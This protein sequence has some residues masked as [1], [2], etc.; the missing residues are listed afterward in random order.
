M[1]SPVPGAGF[2][3]NCANR[4][5]RSRLSL[6]GK[7]VGMRL[8]ALL[9][10]GAVVAGTVGLP[11]ARAEYP[12]VCFA[13]VEGVSKRALVSASPAAE[14]AVATLVAR[15]GGR[16]GARIEPVGVRHV[17]LPSAAVRDAVVAALSATPG[18]RWAEP[19]LLV[20]AHR[21][22]NDPMARGQWAIDKIGLRRA[23]DVTTGAASVTVAV[24]DTGVAADHPDLKGKVLPG[25]DVVNDDEDASDD[26]GHGTH[27][28]GTVAAASNNRR[29]VAGVA[30]GAKVLP[31]KVL[32]AAGSGGTCDVLMGMVEAVRKGA[33]VLN[34]SLG[35]VSPCPLAFK[36]AVAYATQEKRLIVAS[37]GNDGRQGGA[38]AAP[39]NCDGVL[40]VGATNKGDKP[41]AFS[42][43]GPQ[44]DVS[45]PGD[46]ILSTTYDPKRR[47]YGYEA[48]SG[49]SM[50]APHV[51]GLAALIRSKHGDW[52]P[53]QITAA[54][55]E[56]ADDKG[57]PGRD[58]FYGA[59]RIN[60]ARALSR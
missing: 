48:W 28:A 54:I 9:V 55:T 11:A 2:A 15:A 18:V 23:W 22:V 58:D 17:E 57:N 43:F 40:G 33:H 10:A 16:L 47:A 42:T 1:E 4:N 26:H 35:V 8:R 41:T 45:A 37:S 39:A 30:W 12:E 52:T 44:V 46:L 6:A 50:A 56:T 25:I 7:E 3:R 38:S 19:D 34:L 51:A 32:S 59:G 29:G 24:I 14:N 36:A 20:S 5:P 60:A 49:T 31:V 13:G 21:A 53:E 27:V